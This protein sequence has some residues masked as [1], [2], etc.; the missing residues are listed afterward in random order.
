MEIPS[1]EWALV[2]LLHVAR[3]MASGAVNHTKVEDENDVAVLGCGVME[4]VGVAISL[5]LAARFSTSTHTQRAVILNSKSS[6]VCAF[7]FHHPW[8]LA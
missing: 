8:M 7:E 6:F 1:Q 2:P 4:S 5:L 3:K